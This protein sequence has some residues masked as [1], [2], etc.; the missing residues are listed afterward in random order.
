MVVDSAEKSR[1]AL[2]DD[3]FDLMVTD[4]GLPSS[5][6]GSVTVSTPSLKDASTRSAR[7]LPGIGNERLKEP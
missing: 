4:R 5:V 3:R 7:A 2:R 1:A 6:L